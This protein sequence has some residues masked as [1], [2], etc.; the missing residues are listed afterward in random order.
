[1][2][3]TAGVSTDQGRP[4]NH[5]SIHKTYVCEG[6]GREALGCSSAVWRRLKL[7]VP[8]S[9][10][11]DALPDLNKD[12]DQHDPVPK[13]FAP[14]IIRMTKCG[15]LPG[16]RGRWSQLQTWGV[17]LTMSELAVGLATD[18]QSAYP[19]YRYKRT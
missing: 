14:F 16:A 4:D 15:D 2:V 17:E 9:F 19:M 18:G 12:N 3:M 7:Y 13:A 6:V 1:M 5:T 10:Y 11:R 8:R